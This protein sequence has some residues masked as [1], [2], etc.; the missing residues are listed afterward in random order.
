MPQR[1]PGDFGDGGAFA[2]DDDCRGQREQ[3]NQRHQNRCDV[4]AGE[5]K[6][7]E[8]ERL[9]DHDAEDR[10]TDQM[11]A[12]GRRK[13]RQIALSKNQLQHDRRSEDAQ[14]RERHRRKCVQS[15]FRDDVVQGKKNRDRCQRRVY[16]KS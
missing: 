12:I 15:E 8:K 5:R 11:P 7:G 3:R 2:P 16:A 9:I 13:R 1:D 6:A 4:R 14:V 10:V